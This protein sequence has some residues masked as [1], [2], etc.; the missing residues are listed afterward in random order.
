MSEEVYKCDEYGDRFFEFA[1]DSLDL[2]DFDEITRH[3][4]GYTLC[5][6]CIYK[7]LY[8]HYR[9]KIFDSIEEW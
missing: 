1:M 9:E 2:W 3:E 5:K 8:N 4:G 6:G 7:A